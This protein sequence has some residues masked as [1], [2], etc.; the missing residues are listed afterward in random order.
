[1]PHSFLSEQD[2]VVQIEPLLSTD[3][4]Q[5]SFTMQQ[6][7]VNYPEVPPREWE[8]IVNIHSKI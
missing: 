6:G 2:G 1:M 4:G 5:Y 3:E 8:L 7:L